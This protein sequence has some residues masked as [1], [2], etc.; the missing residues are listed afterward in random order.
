MTTKIKHY[1]FLPI[2]FLLNTFLVPHAGSESYTFQCLKAPDRMC[3]VAAYFDTVM[4]TNYGPFFMN[5]ND[6]LVEK[7]WFAK[8][9]RIAFV[10]LQS[11][12]II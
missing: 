9:N 10:K 8:K 6:V 4:K 5:E 11:A 2:F 7:D 3:A 12:K 1:L